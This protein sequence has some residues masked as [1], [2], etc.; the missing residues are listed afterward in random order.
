MAYNKKSIEKASNKHHAIH[1]SIS[2]GVE[3]SIKSY[4]HQRL[5]TCNLL[6]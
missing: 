3:I 5:L 2:T 6:F 4:V 1:H